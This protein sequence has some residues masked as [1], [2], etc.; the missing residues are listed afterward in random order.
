MFS[1]KRDKL[2]NV[3]ENDVFGEVMYHV[4][5]CNMMNVVLGE[6]MCVCACV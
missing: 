2:R 3:S 4:A 6:V 1:E 5:C